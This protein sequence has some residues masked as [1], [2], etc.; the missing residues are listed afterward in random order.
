MEQTQELLY[1]NK[2]EQVLGQT[3]EIA[4]DQEQA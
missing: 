1:N 3:V 2:G 4:E